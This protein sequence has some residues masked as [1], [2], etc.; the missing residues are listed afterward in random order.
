MHCVVCPLNECANN[1]TLISEDC[2]CECRPGFNGPR[3]ENNIN[4]CITR[5]VNCN[6]GE[7]IDQVNGFTCSC[8]L[9]YTGEFCDTV[10]DQC[11]GSNPCLNNGTCMDGN[12]TFTCNC[13]PG[14]TGSTCDQP[15]NI[16]DTNPCLNGGQCRRDLF[17]NFTCICPIN[18]SGRICEI[19]NIE[20]CQV[21]SATP[22]LCSEC[23]TP[24]YNLNGQC[25]K[26]YIMH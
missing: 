5:N 2:Y 8:Y 4:E 10:I 25:R 15:F 24:Y 16:C 20:N 13:A 1:G 26:W 7:C 19:C 14:Y 12:S 11:E 21:C 6:N 23:S 3:C 9:D 22:G 18:F 17:D